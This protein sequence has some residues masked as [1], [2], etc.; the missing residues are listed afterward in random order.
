MTWTENLFSRARDATSRRGGSNGRTGSSFSARQCPRALRRERH[1][2]PLLAGVALSGAS[3]RWSR[4]PLLSCANQAP[5]HPRRADLGTRRST[6][7]VVWSGLRRLR[8][9]GACV[10]LTR[11]PLGGSELFSPDHHC[12][13]RNARL[14]GASVTEQEAVVTLMTA[15]DRSIACTRDRPGA[16]RRRERDRVER[17]GTRGR[18]P[19]RSLLRSQARRDTRASAPRRPGE[20]K[21]ACS[22]CPS[23]GAETLTRA[24]LDRW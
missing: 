5:P 1:P 11:T 20:A 23:R 15:A 7:R 3:A 13:K 6:S 24:D 18:R 9:D 21:R 14:D 4:S 19:Q 16:A 8:D 2:P 17:R 12:M 22:S 10:L